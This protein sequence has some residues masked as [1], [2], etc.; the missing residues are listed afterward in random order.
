V[1]LVDGHRVGKRPARNRR[2]HAALPATQRIREPALELHS[3]GLWMRP[4]TEDVEVI[5]E[6][7]QY[8]RLGPQPTDV[9]LDLGANIGAVSRAFLAHGA[10]HVVAVEPEPR[11]FDLL[12]RNTA[13]YD[14]RITALEVAVARRSGVR[15]LWLSPTSNHGM[16]SLAVKQSSRRRLV[17]C[18]TLDELLRAHSPTLIKADVEGAEYE[19]LA[20]LGALPPSVRGIAMELH[21]DRPLWRDRSA[22]TLM[23]LLERQGFAV[24]E[25]PDL[26]TPTTTFALWLR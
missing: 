14:G 9:L 21:F 8:L 2:W 22:P 20:S 15:P 1:V 18:R 12:L 10:E 4:G 23:K 6:S 19:L 11:N 5:L 17:R 26:A 7:E 25:P 3:S 13:A 16:H 24:E